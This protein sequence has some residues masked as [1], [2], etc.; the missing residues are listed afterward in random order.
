MSVMLCWEVCGFRLG[1]PAH[2]S[3]RHTAYMDNLVDAANWYYGNGVTQEQYR[4]KLMEKSLE[5][6]STLVSCDAERPFATADMEGCERCPPEMP[7]RNLEEGACESCPY[8][9][10]FSQ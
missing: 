2:G 9:Y 5:T 4:L 7:L 3:P 1:F 6:G 8:G 10:T